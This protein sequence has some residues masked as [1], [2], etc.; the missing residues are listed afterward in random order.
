M[1]ELR[2]P[3]HEDLV[4]PLEDFFCE[5]TRSSWML[6]HEGP[7]KPHFVMGYFSADTLFRTVFPARNALNQ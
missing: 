6:F 2:A 4:Q 3:I 5:L 1:I 7:G